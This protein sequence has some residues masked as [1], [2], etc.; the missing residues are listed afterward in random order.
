MC[1]HSYIKTHSLSISPLSMISFKSGN[2]I[3]A[4][5]QVGKSKWREI[6]T[7]Q[8]KKNIIYRWMLTVRVSFGSCKNA[9]FVAIF[10]RKLLHHNLHQMLD[11]FTLAIQP[12]RSTWFSRSFRSLWPSPRRRGCR[13]CR[14]WPGSR[15]WKLCSLEGLCHRVSQAVSTIG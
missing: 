9:K 5:K 1:T 6:S 10:S 2:G 4:W 15:L 12:T 11:F 8:I 7:L 3:K 14:R 13:R